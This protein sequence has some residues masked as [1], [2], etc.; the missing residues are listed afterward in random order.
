[1]TKM[2]VI[3]KG[4]SIPLLHVMW[5]LMLCVLSP[6]VQ[7]QNS[8]PQKTKS[9]QSLSQSNPA[10]STPQVRARQAADLTARLQAQ[11]IAAAAAAARSSVK[12]PAAHAAPT[13]VPPTPAH[14][15]TEA[16]LPAQTAMGQEPTMA[17]MPPMPALERM[18]EPVVVPSLV[19]APETV[20]PTIADLQFQPMPASVPQV[21]S[22]V[23]AAPH[24]PPS[25]AHPAA[26]STDMGSEE[27]AIA[28]RIH[29]GVLPCERGTSVQVQAD[30]SRPGYFR[31]TG[32]GFRYRMHPVRTST[33]ALRLE[34]AQAGAVWLQLANKS[35][36]MDQKKGR[37][38]ADDCAH[39][40]QLA[41]AKEMK[42]N[43]PPKLFETH[44]MGNSKD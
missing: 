25:L 21:A 11:A 22:Q 17:L 5:V 4:L 34:D 31:V 40:E 41:F 30:T 7:A 26:A 6:Q 16:P 8:A 29:Q 14:T 12:T 20:P 44:G 23:S 10:A 2:L 9:G 15:G 32:K 28:Q 1:M 3:L 42:T 37:R 13:A 33:G 35:M 18:T 38:L 19:P 24:Q 27:L 43:P 36:L 39:P